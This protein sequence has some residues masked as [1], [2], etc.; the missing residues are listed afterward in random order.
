MTPSSYKPQEPRYSEVEQCHTVPNHEGSRN[1]PP[2]GPTPR[3]MLHYTNRNH[4]HCDAYTAHCTF[5]DPCAAFGPVGEVGEGGVQLRPQ[6]ERVEEEPQPQP[7]VQLQPQQERVEEESRPQQERVEQ[8]SQLQPYQERVE[9]ES[10][11]KQ[12][13]QLQPQ[14]ESAE[15]EP[16]EQQWGQVLPQQP[17][18][19]A[20]QQRL[21]D[22]PDSAPAH[23]VRG[24]L[25]SP[26]VP[27]D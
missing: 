11:S 6:Q 18:K 16:Q 13:V 1:Y 15:E 25:Q 10:Q 12:Q 2:Q 23:F 19:E 27:S 20:E 4:G 5:P 9:Q 22:L 14:Q 8:E 7:Q 21:G 3:E 24:P 17:P 26:L